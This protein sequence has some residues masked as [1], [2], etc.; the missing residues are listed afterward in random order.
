MGARLQERYPRAFDLFELIRLV[1]TRSGGLNS[2][3]SDEKGNRINRRLE[4]I[5]GFVSL[6]ESKSE[7]KLLSYHGVVSGLE[8]MDWSLSRSK[9]VSAVDAKMELPFIIYSCHVAD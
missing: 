8:S 7:G 4:M 1:S 5:F 3:R 2:K 6:F 9:A